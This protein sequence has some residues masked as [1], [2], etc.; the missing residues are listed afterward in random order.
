[1]AINICL[2]F[3][4]HFLVVFPVC[5]FTISSLHF[6]FSLTLFHKQYQILALRVC[7]DESRTFTRQKKSEPI[8]TFCRFFIIFT[9]LMM[10]PIILLLN[11]IE[12]H[13]GRKNIIT[14]RKVEFVNDIL[15]INNLHG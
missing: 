11:F 4:H 1:M 8:I 2:F 3:C 5:E 6:V 14:A 15:M 9:I 13:N 10:K 7:Q 12:S